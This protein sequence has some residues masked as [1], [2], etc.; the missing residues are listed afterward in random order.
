MRKRVS[1][2]GVWKFCPAFPELESNQRFM[3]PSFDP[4]QPLKDHPTCRNLGWTGRDFD[5]SGWL[6]YE[7]PNS[8]NKAV[9]DLWSYEGIGWYRKTVD[10]PAEWRNRRVEFT[11]D[12]ANYLT[13]VYV[14]GRTAGSHEGGYAPFRI[15]IHDLLSWG[16]PN[17]LAITVDNIPKPERCPGGQYGWWN[18]GGIYRSTGLLVTDM[19]YIDD[20]AVVTDPGDG[21]GSVEIRLKVVQEK[22]QEGPCE[23]VATLFDGGEEIAAGSCPLTFEG[24]L[25][26]ALLKLSVPNPK[27][28]SPDEPNLYALSAEVVDVSSRKPRDRVQIRIGIRSITIDG[29]HLLL[30]GTPLLVKGVNRHPEYPVTGHM[31]REEDLVKDLRLVKA[32]GANALRCHYPNSPRT[33]ELCD[34][35]GILFLSEI[36]LYQWGRPEVQA[37]SPEAL[38]PAKA[39]LAEMIGYLR[40]HACV[41]MWSVSNETMTHP[42][43]D[44]EQYRQLT[45]MT[46]AGNL[47]LID[48]AHKLDPTRPVVEVSNCW[49]EDPVLG[50]TDVCAVNLYIGASSPHVS[51]LYSLTDRMHERLDALRS[52]HPAKPILIGE[53]GSWA[54]RGLKTDHFPGETY[55]AELIRNYWEGLMKEANVVGGFIWVFQDSDVH[56][57]FVW[58]YEF[59]IAYGLYDLNR[60]P[61]EAV[62]TVRKMWR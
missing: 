18:Y 28:W 7:V 9:P 54:I 56:R 35:M 3:D 25:A 14:N 48:L 43:R 52:K 4:S 37:D 27:L 8:W 24:G 5:D 38:N 44:T 15:P 45:E 42:R 59:R 47:E 11:C 22:G 62:E 29:P 31:E 41:F 58:D 12:S 13:V 57:R 19:L 61:K 10:I 1:L 30:N 21:I 46:I 26:E 17:T 20:L 36:P 60:R 49:P 50:R 51:T 55:Q 33:Y 34:E 6:D 23:A 39:Q 16:E 32:L 53:F 2:D 40:N